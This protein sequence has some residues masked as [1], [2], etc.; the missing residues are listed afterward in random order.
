L[1]DPD[2]EKRTIEYEE[3][4][5]LIRHIDAIPISFQGLSM[6]LIR[7]PASLTDKMLMV[8]PD[9]FFIISRFDGKHKISEIQV[10]YNRRFGRLIF[11]DRIRSVMAELDAALLLENDRYRKYMEFLNNEFKKQDYRDASLAGKGYS[12]KPE[13]LKKELDK[14]FTDLPKD[15]YPDDIPTGIAAPHIDFQRGNR[16]YGIAYRELKK[17][18]ADLFIIFGTSHHVAYNFVALTKKTFKTPLGDIPTDG[19]FIDRLTGYCKTDFYR[20]EYLHRNEHSI[21]FQTLMLKYIFPQR[22]IKIVPILVYSFDDFGREGINP[23]NE[24][25]VR[26]FINAMK[27]TINLG[28][29]KPAFVAGIDFAHVGLGFGDPIA[30]TLRQMKSLEE[31]ELKSIAYVEKM[32]ADGFFSDVIKDQDKRRVCG[33]SP[34][35][36]M[37]KCMDADHGRLLEYRQC[38]DPMGFTNVTIAAIGFYPGN[39]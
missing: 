39:N 34:L 4:Y 23:M 28:G 7:D 30:P 17:S 22:N 9:V 36:T 24:P 25:K 15:E 12:D 31:D 29:Y 21:E 5:P 27:K 8:P 37:M 6:I 32:D 11:S 33:L 38:V 3:E 13:E 16:T 2:I 14:F 10:E 18:D 1:K 26:E 35:Y 19:E 20:D